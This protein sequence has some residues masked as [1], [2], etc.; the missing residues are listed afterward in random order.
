VGGTFSEIY[1][2]K[3]ITALKSGSAYMYVDYVR[4]YQ[5]GDKEDI[6]KNY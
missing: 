5:K 3:D 4:V 2:I 6:F 1:D